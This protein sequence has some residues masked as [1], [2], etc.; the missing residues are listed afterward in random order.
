MEEGAPLYMTCAF[1]C[2]FT[3][4]IFG[5]PM[6]IVTTRHMN[7]P[8]V[9]KSPWHCLTSIIKEEGMFAMYKGFIPNVA[10]LGGFNMCLWLTVETLKK[11][12]L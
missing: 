4:V 9:F 12:Y 5:S 7:S 11:N 8:G 3:A 10:R 2:G 1:G 6:D